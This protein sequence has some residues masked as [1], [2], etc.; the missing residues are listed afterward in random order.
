MRTIIP[1]QIFKSNGIYYFNSIRNLSISPST[2]SE[3][4]AVKNSVSAFRKR[5]KGAGARQLNVLTGIHFSAP[6]S[7]C[8]GSWRQERGETEKGGK[9]GIRDGFRFFVLFW[10]EGAEVPFLS[11]IVREALSIA[12]RRPHT[13]QPP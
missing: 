2:C 6:S 5:K 9:K 11:S 1:Q 13:C 12:Q 8:Q 7:S 10:G 3:E 4:K